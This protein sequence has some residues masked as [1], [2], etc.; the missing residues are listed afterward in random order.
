MA[1][2]LRDAFLQLSDD[3]RKKVHQFLCAKALESWMRFADSKK[4]ISYCDSVVGMAH[5]IDFQLPSDAFQTAFG[6]CEKATSDAIAQRYLEP[7]TALQD[8]DLEFPD[9]MEFAYYA[10]YNAFLKYARL[11]NIDDWLIVN[12]ALSAA[13]TMEECRLLLQNTLDTTM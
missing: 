2:N 9:E 6:D 5:N 3:A 4:N 8:M 1:E 12:Q 7:I 13:A 10:I 11:K